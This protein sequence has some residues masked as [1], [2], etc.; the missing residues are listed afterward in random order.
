MVP[1]R[2]THAVAVIARD[3]FAAGV[4][5]HAWEISPNEPD[6][7]VVRTDQ[8]EGVLDGT[9]YHAPGGFGNA[10]LAGRIPT[11]GAVRGDFALLAFHAA[12]STVYAARDFLGTRTLFASRTGAHLA[13]ATS[14]RSLEALPWLPRDINEVALAEDAGNLDLA[15][16]TETVYRSVSRL[17][18]GH[19]WV[20]A[21]DKKSEPR[22]YWEPPVFERTEGA[23][24]FLD[25][26][27]ALRELLVSACGER[28][29]PDDL[30]AIWL[31]GGYDSTAVYGASS[32]FLA[33]KGKRPPQAISLTYPEGDEAREDDFIEATTSHWGTTP[34]WLDATTIPAVD[35]LVGRAAARDEPFTH[36]YELWNRRLA[37]GTVAAGARVAFSGDGG[38]QLF[39]VAPLYFA[40]LVRTG[41]W[42]SIP[43]E[44]R[45]RFGPWHWR[46]FFRLGIQPNLPSSLLS[47]AGAL[48]GAA[49]L[50][51]YLYRKIPSWIRQ[52]FI[53]RTDLYERRNTRP[54]RRPGEGHS[55]WEHS[56]Y[57]RTAFRERVSATQFQFALSEGVEMRTPLMDERIIRLAATRPREESNSRGQNKHLLRSAASGLIPVEVTAPRAKR[58]GMPASYF[59]K[60]MRET[61]SWYLSH[62]T[63]D[64]RLADTGL[65]D[66]A[67]LRS[68]IRTTLEQEDPDLEAASALIYAVHAELWLESRF[69]R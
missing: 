52:E 19:E 64:S 36:P 69:G 16:A 27:V 6:R 26:S 42:F 55:A 30:N 21:F 14:I 33:A 28:L 8:W 29:R 1:D 24:S 53:K 45:E 37:S 7:R 44:W 56:W 11:P 9:I 5:S 62:S 12:T 20:F 23:L 22:R 68:S 59:Y 31:S 25:A 49:P 35:D 67:T 51:H 43:R 13:L 41:R 60:T 48:R 58:T 46:S 65:V 3:G 47:L 2:G 15:V 17:P 63:G 10:V 50:R 66:D 61:L 34:R 4:I 54:P 32:H 18:A 57:F 38:D 40:D 39:S